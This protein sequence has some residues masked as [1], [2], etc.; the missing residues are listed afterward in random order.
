MVP[1]FGE[2]GIVSSIPG[3]NSTDRLSANKVSNNVE[4]LRKL[5]KKTKKKTKISAET[6]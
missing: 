4:V 2:I 1:E 5:E 6:E 3:L